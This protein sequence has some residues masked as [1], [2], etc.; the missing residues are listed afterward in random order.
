M[1]K[2]YNK[3]VKEIS[4]IVDENQ[5]TFIISSSCL[6]KSAGRLGLVCSSESFKEKLLQLIYYLE[7]GYN[8]SEKV[9][10]I[11]SIYNSILDEELKARCSDILTS[12]SNFDRVINQATLVLEDRIRKKAKLDSNYIGTH[13]VNTAIN[14]DLDKSII[15]ISD[16]KEEHEGISYICRGLMQAFRNPTHHRISDFSREE[17][18]KVCAFIDNILQILE[19][20]K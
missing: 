17:A 13:L 11:G 7:Y 15:K 6:Y 10:E 4:V 16:V 18:L 20:A 9:L 3:I 19:D 8:V 14:P 1:V 2:D 12:P 5:D